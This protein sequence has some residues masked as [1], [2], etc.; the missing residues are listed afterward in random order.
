MLA[1]NYIPSLD[2]A[3]EKAQCFPFYVY[4]E[5]GTNRRD[6]ITDWAL[7]QFQ[8]AH[9]ADVTK[10]D[11]FHYVY[12]LLHDPA[13]RTRYAENL[14]RELP[15]IPVD[16]D[17]IEPRGTRG[18]EG[19]E[20]QEEIAVLSETGGSLNMPS[21]IPPGFPVS[22]V[23]PVV[24][25]ASPF[26]RYA[27][28]GAELLRLHR[29]YESAAEYPL[30]WVE[31]RDVPF[32]WRVEKMRLSKDRTQVVVNSSLTLA[33]VPPECFHYRLGNRSALEWVLDQYQVTTDARTALVSDP[34]RHDD[35]EYIARLVGKVIAVSLQTLNL[36]ARLRPDK[37]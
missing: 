3:F 18:E 11:I 12:A 10:W 31:N 37:P 24:D 21:A 27:Q 17:A 9:G 29:D 2:L 36:V 6:N 14:K 20:T 8:A 23:F 13:Y 15:R 26:R 30:Q 28:I 33:G 16:P 5:D 19:K 35:P 34:N 4:D 32:G 25:T 7:G 22:P 1:S